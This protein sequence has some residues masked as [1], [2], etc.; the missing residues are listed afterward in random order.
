MI[1][2]NINDKLQINFLKDNNVFLKE[3]FEYLEKSDFSCLSIGKFDMGYEKVFGIYQ[4]YTTHRIEGH[5]WEAH[6]KYLDLQF[7][8]TGEEL[9]SV[10]PLSSII[11]SREYSEEADV[12][13]G[14]AKGNTK[15]ISLNK[16]EFIILFPNEAHMPAISDS[17][18]SN[19]KKIVVKIPIQ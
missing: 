7:L 1:I 12:L 15:L 8:I 2:G 18:I 3:A 10:S 6:K 5:I 9:V 13:L 19:N 14:T 16:D 4:E 11:V 17:T